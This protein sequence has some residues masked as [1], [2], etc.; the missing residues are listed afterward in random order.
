MAISAVKLLHTVH[1]DLPVQRWIEQGTTGMDAVQR[2][3]KDGRRLASV[4][5]G[6]QAFAAYCVLGDLSPIFRRNPS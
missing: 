5:P 2:G 3:T 4:G 6:R 1:H